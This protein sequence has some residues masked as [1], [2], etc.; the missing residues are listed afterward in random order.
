MEACMISRQVLRLA[1]AVISLTFSAG[2]VTDTVLKGDSEVVEWEITDL[3]TTERTFEGISTY[4]YSFT[5]VLKENKGKTITFNEF[6]AEYH[7]PNCDFSCNGKRS[8]DLRLKPYGKMRIPCGFSYSGSAE[9]FFDLAPI[10]TATFYGYDSPGNKIQIIVKTRLPSNPNTRFNK[11]ADT[12]PLPNLSTAEKLKSE[13]SVPIQIAGKSILVQ[14][15]LNQKERVTLLFDTG[16]SKTLINPDVAKLLGITPD[17]DAPE[18]TFSLIGGRT[19]RVAFTTLKEIKLGD[20]VV[21]D[22]QVGVTDAFPDTTLIDGILGTDFLEHFRFTLDRHTSKL[23][24]SPLYDNSALPDG[25][26]KK[27]R[28][29]IEQH[30]R[31]K[32]VWTKNKTR[33]HLLISDSREIWIPEKTKLEAIRG[34]SFN[35]IFYV[36]YNHPDKG[37]LVGSIPKD[38]ISFDPIEN[39]E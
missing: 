5:L 3:Y 11:T 4:Q 16:S 33:L 39:K 37:S 25:K 29:Q 38:D 10:Y 19:H 18:K 35:D 24:L 31:I 36:K 9:N 21:H 15:L 26:I 34:L 22:L 32:Y 14:A 27:S 6:K 1:L 7:E 2:C 20:A 13:I 17:K 8:I 28:P 23:I 12:E 30:R